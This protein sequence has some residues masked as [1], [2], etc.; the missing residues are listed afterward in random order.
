MLAVLPKNIVY[1]HHYITFNISKY[2][3][4]VLILE[5]VIVFGYRY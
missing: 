2:L 1:I 5:I 4:N 3:N